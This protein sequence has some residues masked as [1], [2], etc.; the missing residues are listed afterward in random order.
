VGVLK[1]AIDRGSRPPNAF[2]G[3]VAASFGTTPGPY[4]TARS[5]MSNPRFAEDLRA[6]GRILVGAVQ[7]GVGRLGG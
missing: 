5:Q 6:I 1:N 4:G 3:K 2:S 7:A